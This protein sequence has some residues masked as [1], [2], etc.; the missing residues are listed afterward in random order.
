MDNN[1]INFTFENQGIRVIEING[2]PWWIGKDVCACFGDQ[3]HNRSIGRVDDYDK[4][5]VP[6]IDSLGR[7]QNATVLNESGIYA[8][9]FAM[10][11]QKAHNNGVSDEYP[12]EVVQRMD[13]LHRFKR[14]VTSEV[15]PS[16]RK[17]GGYIAGQESLEMSQEEF[18]AKAMQVANKVL[19]DRAKRIATLEA[20]NAQQTALIEE[21][22]PKVSYY[23]MILKTPN[24]VLVTQIAKDYGM[25]A[26]RLNEILCNKKIQYKRNGQWLLHQ[27]YADKGYTRSETHVWDHYGQHASSI[28]TKW[29]QKGRQFIYEVLKADGILPICEQ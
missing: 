24:T 1:I 21:M 27:Q 9:L 13:K 7:T 20:Q 4:R 26:K 11:P 14:W 25:S 22:K 29:T 19:E 10:Q 5:V 17:H 28:Q 8:L 3:N 6:I 18:L 2:E 15:L 16:I 12:I 23:E